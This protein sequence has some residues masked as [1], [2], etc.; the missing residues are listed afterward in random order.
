M[1][2]RRGEA[3]YDDDGNLVYGKPPAKVQQDEEGN[4]FVLDEDGNQIP[5]DESGTPLEGEPTPPPPEGE[6]PGAGTGGQSGSSA[7]GPA[8]GDGEASG[9]TEPED[10]SPD[11]T[12]P[13][14]G[15]E[16]PQL[17]DAPDS[18]DTPADP[19]TPAE[20]PEQGG[21]PTLPP[22]ED[23]QDLLGGGDSA[24]PAEP[25]PEP[26]VDTEPPGWL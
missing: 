23:I 14:A 17:P 26:P 10:G 18:P 8:T 1:A 9:Q 4:Y 3:Y 5:T 20:G 22:S 6:D 7:G 19:E 25:E 24:P 13:G 12:S 11:T 16:E 2:V 21:E 15:E